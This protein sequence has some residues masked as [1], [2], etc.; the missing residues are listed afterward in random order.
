[1][2]ESIIVDAPDMQ[3][4]LT[5]AE[6]HLTGV[7]GVRPSLTVVRQ[8][9]SPHLVVRCESG[10]NANVPPTVI[11]K[12]LSE[13]DAERIDP[14]QRFANECATL[15]FLTRLQ[16]RDEIAPRLIHS[17]PAARLMILSD[18]GDHPTLQELLY[19]EGN[20]AVEGRFAAWGVYF[21]QM[22]AATHGKEAEFLAIQRRLDAVSPLCDATIDVR[23]K[24]EHLEACL[25]ALHVEPHSSFYDEVAAVESAIHDAD[26]SPF[27]ALCHCDAGPHNLLCMEDRVTMLDFEFAHFQN[28]LM[29][30]VGARL[31]FPQ[32]YRGRPAP[33]EMVRALETAYRAELAKSLPHTEDDRLFNTALVAACAH[34]ALAYTVGLWRS[35]LKTRLEQ[36]AAYD[37]ELGITPMSNT[38]SLSRKVAGYWRALIAVSEEY[39][40][41]P[42]LRSTMETI[43]A[44]TEAQLGELEPLPGYPAFM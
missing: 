16:E 29:D 42:R 2:D 43:L 31:S 25:A 11:L 8:F 37:V 1:M 32:A 36:G 34:W 7:W 17:D 4:T 20:R 12:Q 41:L 44:A 19:V 33:P 15:S 6:D 21:A 24:V 10:L 27:R 26:G 38:I 30:V 14:T 23:G 28:G 13:K 22:Q 18:L 3:T 5:L 39:N 40:M 35:Y 9:G